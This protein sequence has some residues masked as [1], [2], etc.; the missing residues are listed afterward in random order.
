MIFFI[1]R[2]SVFDIAI[3]QISMKSRPVLFVG[4]WPHEPLDKPRLWLKTKATYRFATC[5]C[6]CISAIDS[7]LVPSY[8]ESHMEQNLVLVS[9]EFTLCSS[10]FFEEF[11]HKQLKI[12]LRICIKQKQ[13]DYHP[14]PITLNIIFQ[15]PLTSSSRDGIGGITASGGCFWES[16]FPC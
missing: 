15:I 2:A 13:E 16:A 8:D 9:R 7:F 5:V 11:L 14:I 10:L 1:Y 6:C 3:S 4:H 12:H